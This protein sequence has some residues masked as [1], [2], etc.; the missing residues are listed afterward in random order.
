MIYKALKHPLLQLLDAPNHPPAPPLGATMDRV[1]VFRASQRFLYQRL[2]SYGFGFVVAVLV[3]VLTLTMSGSSSRPEELIIV[4]ITLFLTV[5]GGIL[6]YFLVRLEYDLRYYIVT[7]RSLRIRQGI[8]LIEESTFTF[9]NIQNI[10][11]HQ[12]PVERLFGIKNLLIE[13]AGGSPTTNSGRGGSGAHHGVLAGIDNAEA[14]RD[15]ILAL[16]KAYRDAG[17]GDRDDA[18]RGSQPAPAHLPSLAT[19]GVG[20]AAALGK[21]MEIRDELH[22]LRATLQAEPENRLLPPV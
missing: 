6:Q 7:D 1:H 21:L 4:S 2:L 18:N 12:N 19:P 3:Q 20:G 11:I 10:S 15:R 17:L 13:T 5:V 22:A 9:A 16:L 14:V 8:M